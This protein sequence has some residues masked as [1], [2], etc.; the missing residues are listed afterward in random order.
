[1]ARKPTGEV[2]LT[3]PLFPTEELIVATPPADQLSARGQRLAERPRSVNTGEVQLTFITPEQEDDAIPRSQ[4]VG[5][6]RYVKLKQYDPF[7]DHPMEG[8]DEADLKWIT[9]TTLRNWIFPGYGSKAR[10][11]VKNLA[12]NAYEYRIVIRS[13]DPSYVSNAGHARVLGDE[14]PNYERI[15]AAERGGD[16]VLEKKIE[17]MT[18]HSEKMRTSQAMV[19]QLIKRTNAPGRAHENAG[20][21]VELLANAWLEFETM[22]DVAQIV[23][24]W[25]DDERHLADTSVLHYLTQGPQY[26]RVKNWRTMLNLANAYL[27]GRIVLFGERITS[28]NELL[29][30]DTEPK[31]A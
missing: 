31:S 20:N 25:T 22:M 7:G 13:R 9:P 28:A 21:M 10:T 19:R 8:L 30:G 26:Q 23:N 6:G 17:T 2:Y 16:H 12:L 3:P 11:R 4:R 24:K 29:A 18:V 5:F 15:M 14:K 1:V 27:N